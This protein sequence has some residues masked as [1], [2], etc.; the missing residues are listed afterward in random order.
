VVT[1][2]LQVERRTGKVRRSNTDILRTVP[3]STLVYSNGVS[4]ACEVRKNRNTRLISGF[5]IDDSW[6]FNQQLRRSTVG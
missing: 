5:W 2:Q 6:S 1:H 3:V 4:N